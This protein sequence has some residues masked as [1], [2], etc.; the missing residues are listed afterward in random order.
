[1]SPIDLVTLL[2]GSLVPHTSHNYYIS[3]IR[4]PRKSGF[5]SFL[6]QMIPKCTIRLNKK[7]VEIDPCLRKIFFKDGSHTYYEYLI[8]SLPLPE[9]IG[10]IKDVPASVKTAADKLL[11]TSVHLVSLGFRHPDIPPYQWFYIYDEEIL[12]V[13]AYSPGHKSPDNV[14]H[15]CSSLQFE[16]YSS[17]K[18]PLDCS[19]AH[20]IEH[21]ITKGQ[22]M[23]LFTAG[24][25]V[26]ADYRKVPYGNVVFEKDMLRNRDEVHHYLNQRG[27]RYI[28]RF[29]EWDYLWS[30][31][32]LLSGKKISDIED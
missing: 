25:I 31:Q 16:I 12:P 5:K 22:E 29:G 9:L 2:Y 18:N 20:L 6:N 17:K 28:G 14:P 23:D 8:S 3:E 15:G 32:S 27:I 1:M 11:V 13:R 30:D 24:D 21:V 19:P 7:I 4:Y 10:M 26:V